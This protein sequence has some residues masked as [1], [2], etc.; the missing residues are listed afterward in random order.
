MKKEE[1]GIL[2]AILLLVFLI[3]WVGY[4]IG[5]STGYSRG[6]E[7]SME[8]DRQLECKIKYGN[9][10]QKDISGDCLKY[11]IKEKKWVN[12]ILNISILYF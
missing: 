4:V 11:F 1:L 5:I 8:Y 6:Y 9:V 7:A 2:I 10:A 12:H 3:G